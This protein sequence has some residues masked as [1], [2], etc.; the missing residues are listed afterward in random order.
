MLRPHHRF[1]SL[2]HVPI[3]NRVVQ[4]HFADLIVMSGDVGE[5][6]ESDVLVRQ[7]VHDVVEGGHFE[8]GKV[9]IVGESID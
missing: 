5:Y 4:N 9:E 3:R 8:I 6:F 1:A 7:L 2:D